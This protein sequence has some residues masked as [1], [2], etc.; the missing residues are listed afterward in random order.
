MIEDMTFKG[1][2][3]TMHA[4]TYMN[5]PVV[6]GFLGPQS[7]P[8]GYGLPARGKGH[9][10]STLSWKEETAFSN[11]GRPPPAGVKLG[12]ESQSSVKKCRARF[13]AG[14]GWAGFFSTSA[15]TVVSH[16]CRVSNL[17]YSIFLFFFISQNLPELPAFIL[18]QKINMM[19]SNTSSV[20]E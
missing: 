13:R 20:I 11:E 12:G 16:V 7:I 18:F 5:D 6:H 3:N 2:K 17:Q 8:R 19:T 14:S 15:L 1:K 4:C 9:I 10:L